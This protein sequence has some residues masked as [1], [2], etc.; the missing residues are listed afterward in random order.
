M[1]V[2]LAKALE[3]WG[4][5]MPAWVRL[6]ATACDASSQRAA[7]AALGLS[8]SAISRIISRSYGAGYDEVERKVRAKW[9]NEDVLCPLYG[10]IR[11][12]SCIRNRRRKAP[13]QN[14]MQQLF[15]AHCPHCP[16]NTDRA[17]V[18]S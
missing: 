8:S 13:P 12:A 9:G 11:L 3:S 14:H 17:E 15:A 16:V 5:D 7:G 6:L 1:S 10:A 18:R 4:A 2:N